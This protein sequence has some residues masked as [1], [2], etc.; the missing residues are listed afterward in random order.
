MQLMLVRRINVPAGSCCSYMTCSNHSE[1]KRRIDLNK[2]QFKS[3]LQIKLS[4]KEE[5]WTTMRLVVSRRH[6]IG[7][8]PVQKD[9]QCAEVRGG[10]AV[11][12]CRCSSEEETCLLHCILRREVWVQ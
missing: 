8:T 6:R 10:Q 2:V 3:T 12:L 9:V 1:Q 5:E 4:K 11:Q 7:R